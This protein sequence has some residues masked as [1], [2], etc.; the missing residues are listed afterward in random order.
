MQ[1]RD[2]QSSFYAG[3]VSRIALSALAFAMLVSTASPSWASE[4]WEEPC[5]EDLGRAVYFGVSEYEFYKDLPS[6]HRVAIFRRIGVKHALCI[7]RLIA[8][9]QHIDW[10]WRKTTEKDVRAELIWVRDLLKGDL[11]ALYEQAKYYRSFND[12]GT[13]LSLRQ[14]L[15]QWAMDNHL[16]EAIFDDMQDQFSKGVYWSGR[17]DMNRL[18]GRGCLPAMMEAARRY[19][20]GDGV[21]KNRGK[22]YYWLKRAGFAGG[23]VSSI[24]ETPHERLF[25]EMNSLEWSSLIS[26][27]LDDGFSGI[28]TWVS[29]F[30]E[31]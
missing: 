2:V 11:K 28:Q 23:D 15:H 8:A 26:N 7:D 22:A 24:L 14:Y 20:T 3:R 12:K 27:T 16:P 6:I 19:L 21:D 31:G 5:Q 9:T 29:G 10:S 17:N 13:I 1:V 25:L 18:T 4:F 30:G